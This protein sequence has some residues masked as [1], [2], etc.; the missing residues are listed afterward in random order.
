MLTIILSLTILVLLLAFSDPLNGGYILRRKYGSIISSGKKRRYLLYVPHSYDPHKPVPLVISLHGYKDYPARQMRKSGWNR[1]AEE[2]G[3]IVV[4]PWGS[5]IPFG[6]KYYDYLDP[7]KNPTPDIIFISDLI[8]QLQKQFNIDPKRIYAN[9]LSNGGGM[10]LALS[11]T[12][13][14]R[15]A[16]I[17][18][19]VGGYFYPLEACHSSRPVPMIAFHGT[20]DKLVS[21]NGGPSQRFDYP[22]PSIPDFMKELALKKGCNPE[23]IYQ[24]IN[25]KAHSTSYLGLADVVL[26][27]IDGGEHAWPV[28]TRIPPWLAGNA[29]TDIDATRVMWEFFKSHPL[30][31]NNF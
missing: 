24:E 6:W 30:S 10:A 5:G 9:G 11:C 14:D 17:G 28:G 26:Y 19:V 7:S 20:A 23:P 13:S 21:Y 8:D 29:S 18:S 22:F 4:Y 1:L 3:F 27:T 12:L 15:I 2:E 16:A 25:S 31:I